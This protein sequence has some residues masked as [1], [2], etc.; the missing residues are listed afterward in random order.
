[1]P[2]PFY[3]AR[4]RLPPAPASFPTRRSSDLVGLLL[5]EP[6][7]LLRDHLARMRPGRA[8]MRIVARPHDVVGHAE[9]QRAGEAR[10]I[11]LEGDEEDR[12]STR[13]NSSHQIISYAVFCL[14]KKQL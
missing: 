12:K 5:G 14:I 11:V 3:L 9:R 8:A 13:L 7:H 1:P 6:A 2:P 10:G 4:P